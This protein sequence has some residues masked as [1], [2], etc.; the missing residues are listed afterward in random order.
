[1]ESETNRL[2]IVETGKNERLQ[3][4]YIALW[5]R[6]CERWDSRQFLHWRIVAYKPYIHE[7]T[8]F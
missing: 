7:S 2:E 1:M 8:Q 6:E 5:A 4:F 3:V